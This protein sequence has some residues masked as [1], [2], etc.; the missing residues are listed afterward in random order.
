MLHTSNLAVLLIVSASIIQEVLGI[1]LKD[2]KSR[3]P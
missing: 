3:D 1:K 2:G